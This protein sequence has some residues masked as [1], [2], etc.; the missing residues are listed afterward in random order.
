MDAVGEVISRFLVGYRSPVKGEPSC[1]QCLRGA[2][3]LLFHLFAPK[4]PHHLS[5]INILQYLK[6][7]LAYGNGLFDQGIDGLSPEN[8]TDC[9]EASKHLKIIETKVNACPFLNLILTHE[10]QSIQLGH[11]QWKRPAPTPKAGH[12]ASE[13][14]DR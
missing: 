5:E 13:S 8:H 11:L 3:H 12:P 2:A 14:A 10:P 6:H 9:V 7:I 1:V 4:C